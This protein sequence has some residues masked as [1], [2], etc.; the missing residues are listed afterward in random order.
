MHLKCKKSVVDVLKQFNKYY[1]VKASTTVYEREYERT[2][3]YGLINRF[4]DTIAR[5]LPV[6][7][8]QAY[9]RYYPINFVYEAQLYELLKT[10]FKDEI[11]YSPIDIT[12]EPSHTNLSIGISYPYDSDPT[13]LWL[14]VCDAYKPDCIREDFDNIKN[15]TDI[16]DI[17]KQVRDK[18]DN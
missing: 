17:L 2:Q 11:S 18:Y 1:I 7:L 5:E 10:E 4:D 12:Y 9:M 3:L 8:F 13:K 16:V 6:H 14:R 15:L